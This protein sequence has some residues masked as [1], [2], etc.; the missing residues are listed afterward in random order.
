MVKALHKGLNGRRVKA[1]ELPRSVAARRYFHEL[2]D[3]ILRVF[4]LKEQGI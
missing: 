2:R 4:S 3:G 1:S